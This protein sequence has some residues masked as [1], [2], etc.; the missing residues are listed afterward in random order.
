MQSHSSVAEMVQAYAEQAIAIA[1][2][3]KAELDY[4]ENS[5]ME[6]E[7][8]LAQLAR[9]MPASKPSS[10]D[11]SEMCKMW[12]SYFGEVVR[13]R[14]GGEWSIETYP[15]KQFATLTLNVSD[16]KLFPS[17]KIHRRLSEGDGDNVWTFYKMV[18]SRLEAKLGTKIQ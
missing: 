13:R 10:D 12:G 16:N 14:F 5:L 18:R 2:E 15:G 3:F 17:L 8:I 6:V 7:T 4:S 1:R 11:L 9:E